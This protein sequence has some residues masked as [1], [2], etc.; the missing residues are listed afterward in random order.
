MRSTVDETR[1]KCSRENEK[2]PETRQNS[3]L[4]NWIYEN[5]FTFHTGFSLYE[6][7]SLWNHVRFH[8]LHSAGISPH[9]HF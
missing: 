7:V 5:A 6:G 9:V 4:G 8:P 2:K 1:E 3:S